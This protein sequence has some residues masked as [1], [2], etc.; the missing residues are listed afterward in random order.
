MISRMTVLEQNTQIILEKLQRIEAEICPTREEG[1]AL[2]KRHKRSRSPSPS[3]KSSAPS[4]CVL[5]KHLKDKDYNADRLREIGGAYGTVTD[6]KLWR[7][8]KTSA[9]TAR[10]QFT[11]I[12]G[13]EEMMDDKDNLYKTRGMLCIEYVR[14]KMK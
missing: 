1:E 12:R 11:S 6:V 7:D 4:Y 14:R 2:P 10:I 3:P 8:S 13:V 5:L 9:Y